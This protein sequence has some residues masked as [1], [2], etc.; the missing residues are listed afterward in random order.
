MKHF[1][2]CIIFL[3]LTAGLGGGFSVYG[4][5]HPSRPRAL[6]EK[7]FTARASHQIPFSWYNGFAY[8]LS[9]FDDYRQRTLF[10]SGRFQLIYKQSFLHSINPIARM[11]VRQFSS[12]ED[13]LPA[14]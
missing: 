13:P 9:S 4:L 8:A 1:L 5:T 10:H 14:I 12:T 11:G 7:I 6:T 3:L 2:T